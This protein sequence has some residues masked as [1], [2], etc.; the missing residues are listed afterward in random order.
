MR[1]RGRPT[2]VAGASS[3]LTVRIDELVRKQLE[4]LAAKWNCSLAGGFRQCVNMASGREFP[5]SSD[6]PEW[7][8]AEGQRKFAILLHGTD[9][10]AAK[11][12]RYRGL[13]FEPLLMKEYW[14]VIS[15][16]TEKEVGYL[17]GKKCLIFVDRPLIRVLRINRR[18]PTGSV[19]LD[20]QQVPEG[21]VVR[22]LAVEDRN[23]L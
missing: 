16:A 14:T 20:E 15:L 9:D 23:T 4:G 8:I 11:M 13:G 12:A 21:T 18:R 10:A 7:I 17:Q 5:G 19:F 6:Q 22:V 1:K 3:N 2:V